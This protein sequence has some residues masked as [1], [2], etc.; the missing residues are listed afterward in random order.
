M[1]LQ[2]STAS[3]DYKLWLERLDTTINELNTQMQ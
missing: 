2:K 1:K 3:V